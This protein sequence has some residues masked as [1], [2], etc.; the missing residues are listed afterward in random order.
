MIGIGL[1]IGLT[2]TNQSA[3]KGRRVDRIYLIDGQFCK[4]MCDEYGKKVGVDVY[5]RLIWDSVRQGARRAFYYDSLPAK[6]DNQSEDDHES[7][8]ELKISELDYIR[9]QDYFHV[10]D[11]LSRYRS[12]KNRKGREQ[13]GVDILLALDAFRFAADGLADEIHIFTSDVDFYPVF[14]ALQQTGCRGVLRYQSGKAPRELIYSADIAHFFTISEVLAWCGMGPGMADGR[15]LFPEPITVSH[16][17]DAPI[18]HEI[19]SES[20]SEL[21]LMVDPEN[22][23]F[24]AFCTDHQGHRRTRQTPHPIIAVEFC[25]NWGAKIEYNIEDELISKKAELL[26]TL[27][28]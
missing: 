13:K 20:V 27:T 8:I 23:H 12:G 15:D 2:A 5:A 4:G 11:G 28:R 7:E 26:P 19:P 24:I 3:R 17:P 9:S 18:I 14:E 22:G 21:K 16:I 10:K 25:R 1:G 6:K